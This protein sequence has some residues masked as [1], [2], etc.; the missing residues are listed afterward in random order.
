MTLPSSNWILHIDGSSTKKGSGAGVQLQ[1]L[2]GKL[3]RQS[4][5]FGFP[6]SN[7]EA[8][9]ESLI[10][11]LCFEKA[12]KAKRLSSYCDS[13]L[14][15]S[16]FSGDYDARNNMMDAYLKI[17]QTLAKEF[18][19][20][21]LT[22]V[23]RGDNV[24]ADALTALGSKLRDQVKQ[25]I[26]IHRIDVPAEKNSMVVPI[27]EATTQDATTDD[28]AESTYWRAEF[29]DFLSNGT[30]PTEKW[31]ARRLKT[32]SAHY[33]VINSELFRWTASK[34]L[35][36]CIHSDETWSYGRHIKAR[37]AIIRE[38]VPWL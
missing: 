21:E 8:E 9:Y 36:K 7:N 32:R 27:S 20:F 19:F 10:V 25:T 5:S 37:P 3:I 14:V 29:I 13:Q 26:P 17:V 35:L 12:V 1:S 15:A 28:S 16:Q 38:V 22:K 2:T 34:V 4:F 11:G 18:E 33:V 6:T 31:A 23:L 24:C 30:L